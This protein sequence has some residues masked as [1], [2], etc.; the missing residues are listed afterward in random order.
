MVGASP[1]LHSV[2]HTV[3]QTAILVLDRSGA[4]CVVDDGQI[5][6]SL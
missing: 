2:C 6:I 3:T 4:S 5:G 1:F